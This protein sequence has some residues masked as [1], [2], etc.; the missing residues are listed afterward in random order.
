MIP[1]VVITL[2]WS[3][4]SKPSPIT[5]CADAIYTCLGRRDGAIETPKYHRTRQACFDYLLATLDTEAKAGHR[6]LLG[7][8]FALGYPIGFV[9]ALTG[10]SEALGIWDLL[11]EW[12]TDEPDNRNNR[13]DVAARL[14]DQSRGIGPFWGCPSTAHFDALPHKGSQRHGHGF[15]ERR[16]VETYVRSTQTVWKLFTTG[17]VGSQ[18]L[19]GIPMV[20]RLRQAFGDQLAA[21]PFQS[22]DTA[23]IVVSEIYPSYFDLNGVQ[24][25]G[26][27]DIKDARQ[28]YRVTQEFLES[29]VVSKTL[30]IKD[31]SPIIR[32]EGWILGVP[33]P[34]VCK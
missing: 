26:I 14:N 1:D 5:P 18:S 7:V 30:A 15:P 33:L 34:E 4:R 32:E 11:S 24:D 25:G 22:C 21:W 10:R 29:D 9:E 6:V 23:S 3:S 8:D 16:L 12:I 20:N 13:F 19:L 27:F 31:L 2:D 28:V 17:S